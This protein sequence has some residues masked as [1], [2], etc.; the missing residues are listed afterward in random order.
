MRTEWCLEEIYK[1]FEDPAY[2]ADIQAVKEAV[3][4]TAD[5]IRAL[6]N[7]GERKKAKKLLQQQ[8]KVTELLN[9]LLQYVSLRQSVDTQNGEIMAQLNR[10]Q[11]IAAEYTPL[12]TAIWKQLARVGR[13]ELC[14]N[15]S[16]LCIYGLA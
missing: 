12:E 3:E 4:E 7:A 15:F 10:L 11:K 1:G 14:H 5:L 8:E 16:I 2:G 6:E 13:I 9:R